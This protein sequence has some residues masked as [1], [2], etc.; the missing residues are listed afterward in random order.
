VKK[1]GKK[2]PNNNRANAVRGRGTPT[3]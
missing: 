3:R 2:T 1:A